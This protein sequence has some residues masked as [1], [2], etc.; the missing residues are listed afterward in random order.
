[1]SIFKVSL[2]YSDGGHF[3]GGTY[4][5]E[6]NES[7]IVTAAH[8]L[9]ELST[10][11]LYSPEK[12]LFSINSIQ[13]N[14]SWIFLHFIR[15]EWWVMI[16]Q[17]Q[18]FPL[19]DANTGILP[20]L[21]SIRRIHSTKFPSSKHEGILILPY[22]LWVDCFYRFRLIVSSFWI[23]TETQDLTYRIV[24]SQSNIFGCLW[25]IERLLKIEINQ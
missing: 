25:T 15:L 2:Q 22:Y 23:S 6:G 14:I 8:C 17:F 24:Q 9:F 11:T 20:E 3:C 18:Q 5:V 10:M 7:L 21:Q 16:Y 1:M 13:V 12:V 19:D 4:V